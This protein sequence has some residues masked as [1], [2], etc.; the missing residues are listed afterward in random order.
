[1]TIVEFGFDPTKYVLE[2]LCMDGNEVNFKQNLKILMQKRNLNPSTVARDLG[3][4]R[5]TF[6]SWVHGA[7]PQNVVAMK[8]LS[9]YF[10]ISLEELI[11]GR[12]D[13]QKEFKSQVGRFEITVRKLD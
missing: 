9:R 2:C 8:R 11:M 4:N 3:I 6:F 5:S 12:L 13:E 10:N 1:M 7:V